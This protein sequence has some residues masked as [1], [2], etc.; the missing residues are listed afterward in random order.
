[1]KKITAV[2]LTKN[3]EKNIEACL[4]SLHWCDEII[5]IDDYSLDKTTKL[6][7][8]NGAKVFQRRLKE[9]FA[10]QRNFGLKKAGQEWVFFVDADERVSPGL[11]KEIIGKQSEKTNF[12]GFYLKRKD[13]FGNQWLKYGET[14]RT[15]FLRL[16]K[17]NH[18]QWQRMVHET[19]Q[20]KGKIG[21]L[22]SPLLHYHYSSLTILLKKIN[23]YS[24]LHA[25]VFYQEGQKTNLFLILGKPLAKFFRNWLFRFG[26]LDGGAGLIIALMMSWHSFLSQAKLYQRWKK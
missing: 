22:K 8:K 5:V 16:A 7:K 9:N 6:A 4:E 10:D 24:T 18:G 14:S 1:M 20:V 12:N 2:V 11:R 23:F 21:K 3:E 17:K 26:F 15:K 25:E 19:W 13:F